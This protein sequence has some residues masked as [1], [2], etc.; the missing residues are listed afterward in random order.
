MWTGDGR[1][2]F[3]NPSARTSVWERPEELSG[4]ADVTKMITTPPPV[5]LALRKESQDTSEDGGGSSGG[6]GPSK[7]MKLDSHDQGT[8]IDDGCSRT[9]FLRY[10]YFFFFFFNFVIFSIN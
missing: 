8:R 6:G 1:V 3:Y 2:F 9:F 10:L 4:R 5:V 7:K